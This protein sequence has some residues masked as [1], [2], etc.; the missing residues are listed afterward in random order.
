MS[1]LYN[2]GSNPSIV[3]YN[4]TSLDKVIYSGKVVWQRVSPSKAT[5]YVSHPIHSS[6]LR[7]IGDQMTCCGGHYWSGSRPTFTGD[8]LEWLGRSCCFY[9]KAKGD[10]K[11]TISGSLQATSLDS[12]ISYKYLGY[13]NGRL[14]ITYV[15]YYFPKY[16]LSNST[17]V[18]TVIN[19]KAGDTYAI[20]L[21]QAGIYNERTGVGANLTVSA[22]PV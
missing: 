12:D 8:C 16:N 11:V 13:Y 21:W 6:T 19:M 14:Y 3:K 22:T 10:C 2:K 20:Y 4:G 15:Y 1:I 17:P 9:F 18:N 7:L 5:Y